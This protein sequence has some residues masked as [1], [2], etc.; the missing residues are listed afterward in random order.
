MLW[1]EDAFWTV[2]SLHPS[3]SKIL[4]LGGERGVHSTMDCTLTS[5]SV[6]QGSILSICNNSSLDVAKI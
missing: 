5:H 3:A 6:A 1:H 4:F 2:L